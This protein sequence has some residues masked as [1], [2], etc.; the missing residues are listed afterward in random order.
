MYQERNALGFNKIIV[1]N[2]IVVV[3]YKA[4][5]NKTRWW[6]LA[7]DGNL[8][9]RLICTVEDIIEARYRKGVD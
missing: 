4:I 9:K 1:Q 6:K 3:E 8:T 2:Q 5:P 7:R